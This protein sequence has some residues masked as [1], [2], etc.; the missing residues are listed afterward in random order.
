MVTMTQKALPK[1]AMLR[2]TPKKTERP[3]E[4]RV[5]KSDD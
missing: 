5:V 4:P 3:F 1:V 2:V